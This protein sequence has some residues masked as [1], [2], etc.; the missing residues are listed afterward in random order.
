MASDFS[1]KPDSELLREYLENN[2]EPAFATLVNR[3]LPMVY[4]VALRHLSKQ[5]LAEET[6]QSAFVL[7]AQRGRELARHPSLAGWLYR[8]TINLARNKAQAEQRRLRREAAAAE[9][10]ATMKS[11]SS[12]FNE[13]APELDEALLELNENDR[14]ALLLRFL[15]GKTIRE[16]G[17]ALKIREDAAQKRIAKAMET[18][19]QKLRR[20]GV[21]VAS[22][23]ILAAALPQLTAS[24]VPAALP[25]AIVTASVSA[26][27]AVS[28]ST[29]STALKFMLL[30]KEITV[31][32]VALMTLP[33][34]YEYYAASKVQAA[35]NTQSERLQRA[36][37]SIAA[38]DAELN[39]TATTAPISVPIAVVAKTAGPTA[40]AVPADLFH[41]NESSDYVRLPL[42]VLPKLKFGSFEQ[43]E[44]RD[45]KKEWVQ[46]LPFNFNGAPDP[47][48]LAALG[49]SEQENAAVIAA[50]AQFF[51]QFHKLQDAH[52]TLE[53]KPWPADKPTADS[54]ELKTSTFGDEGA[55]LRDNYRAQLDSLLGPER[56]QLFW[57]Q[58]KPAFDE[59]LN[60][61]GANER[62]LEVILANNGIDVF[63]FK[64]GGA[65]VTPLKSRAAPLPPGVQQM[66]D[67]WKKEHPGL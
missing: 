11:E 30:K 7:L 45:G 54:I 22:V 39:Q 64:K 43:R 29:L 17:E 67:D 28:T 40:P 49:L 59:L 42:A 10:S 36:R 16:V 38:H 32:C 20:R 35:V 24:A 56:A 21:R 3:H 52:S 9:L 33:V 61:F 31:A 5:D 63:D 46:A 19:L 1:E 2:S 47:A 12:S 23:A 57:D 65:S 27:A 8:T 18:L 66:V 37:E 25:G 60:D 51:D 34:G 50:S 48:L 15:Q 6:A 14:E 13:L 55:A 53:R 4:G 62:R 44:R 58:A 26:S 41:W